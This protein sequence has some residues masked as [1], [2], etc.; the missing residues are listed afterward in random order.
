MYVYFSDF[1]AL[2]GKKNDISF[3]PFWAH[4]RPLN[5]DN[6]LYLFFIKN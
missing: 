4:F 3:T 2:F 6:A 1:R 5:W